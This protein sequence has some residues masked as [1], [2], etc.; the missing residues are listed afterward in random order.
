[1]W[2]WLVLLPRNNRSLVDPVPNKSLHGDPGEVVNFL[3][4]YGQRYYVILHH[5]PRGRG[6][7]STSYISFLVVCIHTEAAQHCSKPLQLFLIFVQKM[8]SKIFHD[9]KITQ[10]HQFLMNYFFIW[11][12]Y[13][14]MYGEFLECFPEYF[15][16]I[17][18]INQI[19]LCKELSEVVSG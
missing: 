10:Q 1:M 13:T 9:L 12:A 16:L 11:Y 4:L 14:R 17:K 8:F 5:L 15:D 2:A 7:V 19:F 6:H 18:S 3:W